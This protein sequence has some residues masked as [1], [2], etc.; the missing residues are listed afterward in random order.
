[1]LVVQFTP[2]MIKRLSE[3]LDSPPQKGSWFDFTK[4]DGAALGTAI[5]CT[6]R[7]VLEQCPGIKLT[8]VADRWK[9]SVEPRFAVVTDATKTP[10]MNWLTPPGIGHASVDDFP[11][12]QFADLV[13][14]GYSR[15]ELFE[16]RGQQEGAQAQI[17]DALVRVSRGWFTYGVDDDGTEWIRRL[18]DLKSHPMP[19]RIQ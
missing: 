19:G 5:E 1:V 16:A 4:P 8:A 3:S 18:G 13:A 2:A 10:A 15:L 17:L 6:R 14:W 12:L 11:L 9:G 7:Y